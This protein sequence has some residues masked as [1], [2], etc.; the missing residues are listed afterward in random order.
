MNIKPISFETYIALLYYY[1]WRNFGVN[2]LRRMVGSD[3][4]CPTYP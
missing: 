4:F 2:Q 3:G 1:P